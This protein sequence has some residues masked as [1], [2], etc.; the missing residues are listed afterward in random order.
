MPKLRSVALS[1]H[2]RTNLLASG[3][4][5]T[6]FPNSVM[7]LYADRFSLKTLPIDLP[8]RPWPVVIVTVKN[9]TLSPVVELFMK[10]L[11]DFTKSMATE[12]RVR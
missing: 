7:R 9:R 11:R 4:H 6:T 12:Q 2:I 10:H 8:V 3:P 1:T 5:I